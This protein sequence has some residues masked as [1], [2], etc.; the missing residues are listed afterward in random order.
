[1]SLDIMAALHSATGKEDSLF[2]LLLC[3]EDG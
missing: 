1:M 2:I 3:A